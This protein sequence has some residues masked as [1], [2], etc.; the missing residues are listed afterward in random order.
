MPPNR[1][2][3]KATPLLSEY[4]WIEA[5]VT[6]AAEDFLYGIWPSIMLAA[7][8]NG[9][10]K[11]YQRVRNRIKGIKSRKGRDHSH[12]TYLSPKE[13]VALVS[14]ISQI[15]EMNI[16][17]RYRHLI[18]AAYSIKLAS[19]PNIVDVEPPS[20]L[21][22]SRWLKRHPH[23]YLRRQA[24]LMTVPGSQEHQATRS[25]LGLNRS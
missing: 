15:D 17:V 20:R 19:N 9:V 3:K 25:S 23:I 1:T 16:Y 8:S 5:K 21:W 7:R 2:K 10:E 18:K 12:S 22:P 24:P 11:Q 14:Y 6:K 13:D 4:D